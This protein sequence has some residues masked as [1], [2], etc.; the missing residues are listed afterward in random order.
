MNNGNYYSEINTYEVIVLMEIIGENPGTWIPDQTNPLNQ[1]RKNELSVRLLEWLKGGPPLERDSILK[2]TVTQIEPISGRIADDYGPWSGID[3]ESQPRVLVFC[4]RSGPEESPEQMFPRCG[5]V[6]RI[7]NPSYPFALEDV[8]LAMS[9]KQ[10]PQYPQVLTTQSFQDT[11]VEARK[12]A[13]PLLARFL[14]AVTP[15]EDSQEG[16]EQFYDIIE[17]GDAQVM[18]RAVLLTHLAEQMTLIQNPSLGERIRL[19]RAMVRIL[20]EPPKTARTI[21]EGIEQAYLYNTVFDPS[22]RPYL[23]VDQVYAEEKE[24]TAVI[25]DIANANFSERHRQQL[26]RWLRPSM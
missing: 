25:A 15:K 1:Q 22:G 14:I 11:M 8:R 4:N 10:N 17:A 9:I 7:P 23:P 18:F 21:Q 3:L 12:K 16:A 19:I 6:I 5:M 20:E 13:G 24:R 26:M 2:F